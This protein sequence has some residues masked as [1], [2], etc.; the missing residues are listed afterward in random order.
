MTIAKVN[1]ALCRTIALSNGMLKP[2]L[3]KINGV[4]LPE[5]TVYDR[6]TGTNGTAITSHTPDIDVPTGGWLEFPTGSWTIQDNRMQSVATVGARMTY[7]NVGDAD[8]TIQAEYVSGGDLII[9]MN[10]TNGANL[11]LCRW[12]STGLLIVERVASGNTTRATNGSTGPTAGDHLVAV[13]N[14]DTIS[15]YAHGSQS[16][17]CTYTVASRSFKTN[18]LHSVYN[19]GGVTLVSDNFMLSVP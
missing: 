18:T 1:G 2:Q 13:T 8:V 12:N 15:L 3:D 9:G 10:V 7:K 19:V 16:Y 17:S 11:W 14:G 6:F 4:L 5:V